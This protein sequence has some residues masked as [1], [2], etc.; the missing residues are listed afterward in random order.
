M[1]PVRQRWVWVLPVAVF[2]A[3]AG[4]SLSFRQYREE[5]AAHD[6]IMAVR[7]QTM[8]DALLAGVRAHGR[9]GRYRTERLSIVFE[10]LAAAPGVVGL[11]LIDRDGMP[12]ASGGDTTL[13]EGMPPMRAAWI[14]RNYAMSATPDSIEP[15]F[16]EPGGPG[17]EPGPPGPPGRPP[18]RGPGGGRWDMDEEFSN[19]PFV[20]AVVLDGSDVLAQM[21]GDLIQFLVTSS[22]VVLAICLG[23]LAVLSR[24]KRRGLEAE[25]ALAHERAAHHERLAQVAAGLTHE[26]KNPLGVVRGL[27]QS[28][29]ALPQ[30]DVEIRRLAGG[31]IDEADR[32]VGQ[33]NGFLALARPKEPVQECIDMEPFL[34]ELIALVTPEAE[35]LG[36]SLRAQA[37]G[38]WVKADPDLL[39]RLLLNLLLNA[40]RASAEDGEV[41]VE[42]A[43]TQDRVTLCVVDHGCGIPPE[44]LGR[45]TEPYFSKFEGG[46]G[47]GLSI[48]DQIVRSHGWMMR[49]ESKPGR[50]TKVSITGI[51]AVP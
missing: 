8:L 5:R 13:L 34:A 23:A 9:M 24:M 10:E 12:V 43:R 20:L 11:T 25:L 30:T 4:L 49:F 35:R 6:R 45:I 33:I 18:G 42:V 27:A 38:V 40:L 29:A 28:I 31:I 1:V 50:G 37:S 48:A 19:G 39:R 51:H 41:M 26:T 46:T 22:V 44:H 32:T 2:I 14:G 36:V 16:R 21:R 47:L 15:E 7:A 17:R 3:A